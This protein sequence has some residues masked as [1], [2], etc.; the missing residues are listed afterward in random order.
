M[1]FLN[2]LRPRQNGCRFADD[3]FKC[4]F[5]NGNCC[6]KF[7]L[8]FVPQG[9]INNIPALVQIMAWC[10]SGDMPLSKP[11]MVEFTDINV[12]LGLNE[13]IVYVVIND[14]NFSFAAQLLIYKIVFISANKLDV[15]KMAISTEICVLNSLI[16]VGYGTVHSEICEIACHWGCARGLRNSLINHSNACHLWCHKTDM[17][18]SKMPINV[19]PASTCV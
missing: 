18:A 5:L 3:N 16:L 19:L 1:C 15:R 7:S 10:Q 17:D 11:M 8:K 4:I 6:M 12:L 13:L 2:T 14:F 9:P